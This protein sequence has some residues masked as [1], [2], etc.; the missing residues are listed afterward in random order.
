MAGIEMT[1]QKE[2]SVSLREFLTDKI[3]HLEKRMNDRFDANQ[4]AISA[5]KE[6]NDLAVSV[7][8]ESTDRSMEK[9]NELRGIVTDAQRQFAVES[10]V[11]AK[12][13]SLSGK[14]SMIEQEQAN[15]N[16][17]AAG[18]SAAAFLMATLITLALHFLK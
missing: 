10:T 3:D 12:F 14:V 4:L 8:K 11:S 17:R 18:F 5:A 13:D 16:G 7:A 6:S 1:A 9:L 15:I 2:E